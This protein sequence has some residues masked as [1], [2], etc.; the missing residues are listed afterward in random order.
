MSSKPTQSDKARAYS[1]MVHMFGPRHE[2]KD[3]VQ[4]A[5]FT[6][7]EEHLARTFARC[8]AD[9]VKAAAEESEAAS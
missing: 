5:M 7:F 8:R 9:A 2:W 4:R 6:D 1:A 3:G